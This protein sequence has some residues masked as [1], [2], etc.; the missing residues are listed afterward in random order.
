MKLLL[1][2]LKLGN[3]KGIKDLFIPVQLITNI[4]GDN[5]TGKTTLF[6]AF[7]YLLFDK[8]SQDRSTFEIKPLDKDNNPIH[9][10]ETFVEGTLNLEGLNITLKKVFKEKWVKKRGQTEQEFSGHETLYY[11]D[12]V[13][14]KKNEYQ[15]YIADNFLDEKTFKLLTNPFGFENLKWQDKRDFLF[16]MCGEVTDQEIIEGDVKLQQLNKYLS[17]KDI[18]SFKKRITALKKQYKT[19]IENIPPRIDELTNSLKDIDIESIKYALKAKEK[20]AVHIE[21]QLEVNNEVFEQLRIKQ[22]EVAK[23]VGQKGILEQK[24]SQEANKQLYNLKGLLQDKQFA[25]KGNQIKLEQSKEYVSLLQ[26]NI[27]TLEDDM[28]LLRQH[29]SDVLKEAFT[30]EIECVCPTCKQALPQE[31]IEAKKEEMQRNFDEDKQKRLKA[32]NEKGVPKKQAKVLKEKELSD[33]KLFE[34]IKHIGEQELEI[35]EIKVQIDNFVP[36]VTESSELKSIETNIAL[37]RKAIEGISTV[38]TT[39]LKTTKQE[40]VKEM[41][42]LK[43]QLTKATLQ[44]GTKLRIEDLKVKHK[45]LNEQLAD[46]EKQEFLC[47]EFVKSKVD[48][49]EKRINSRFKYVSFKLFSEQVN[50]GIAEC[51]ESLIEGVPFSNANN[52][53]QINAGLDIINSFTEYYNFSAPIFVDNAESVNELIETKSQIIRLIVSKD[54]EL[55]VE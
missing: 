30:H 21:Q 33:T 28:K 47:E 4:S 45:A 7:T 12:G 51:C 15:K 53:A 31:N 23:L 52:A 38:D 48:V 55:V 18:D 20:E 49:L 39:E 25:L 35:K 2:G 41:D 13:P 22:Q 9:F 11:I 42:S 14:T 36:N 54:K 10:L 17:G 44:E 34:I 40:I 19:D 37:Q 43:E 27:N 6:D 46:V 50:G 29:Y 26:R 24:L 16:C 1:K 3:F 8:D 32:I 5:A